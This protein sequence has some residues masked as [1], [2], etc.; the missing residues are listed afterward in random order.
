MWALVL[1]VA[2]QVIISNGYDSKL[3]CEAAATEVRTTNGIV[4]IR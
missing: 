1:M 4:Q 2:G 3:F